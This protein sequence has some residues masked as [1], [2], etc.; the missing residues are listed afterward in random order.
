M[1]RP[2]PYSFIVIEGNI[3]AGKTTLATKLAPEHQARLIL[4][5]FADNPFLP[6]FYAD[7]E[8][9]AFPLEMSFLAERYS[10]L[11]QELSKN[12]LFRPNLVSDYNFLKSLIFAKAN[13]Q[14]DEYDLY[15]R[16]FHI[17]NNALPKP[18]LLVYLYHNTERLQQNIRKRGREYEQGIE[19]EYLE[20]IQASYFEFFKQFPEQRI[21][22]LDVNECDFVNS[23]EQYEA[24]KS[25]FFMDFPKGLSRMKV[26]NP[27]K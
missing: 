19:N 13:L 12:D 23:T 5:Q 11:Q 14:P 9:Y 15:T 4:E 7:K 1:N 10:Q 17:I 8:K 2:I 21:L 24:L 18:D 25:V 27:K 16:L 20:K 3:G 22:I 6:K 26:P